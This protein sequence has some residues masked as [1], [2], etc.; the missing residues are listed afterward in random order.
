MS[1]GASTPRNDIDELLC[2]AVSM[3]TTVLALEV[4]LSSKTGFNQLIRNSFGSSMTY[5]VDVKYGC[6]L[7]M[8]IVCV[9]LAAFKDCSKSASYG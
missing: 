1:Q 3:S 7:H 9:P 2:S 8:R 4:T 5:A 6:S